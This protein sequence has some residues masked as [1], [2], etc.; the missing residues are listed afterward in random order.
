M[1]TGRIVRSEICETL[2]LAP[3]RDKWAAFGWDAHE[4]AGFYS[5]T[6][7]APLMSEG[8]NSSP[9]VLAAFRLM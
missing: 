8:E 3:L 4:I 7:S 2:M 9:S 1:A 6:S 5:I